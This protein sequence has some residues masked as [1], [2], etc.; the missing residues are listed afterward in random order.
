MQVRLASSEGA[1][2]PNA[3][4][5]TELFLVRAPSQVDYRHGSHYTLVQP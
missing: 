4:F 2:Y 1:R 3:P 5:T